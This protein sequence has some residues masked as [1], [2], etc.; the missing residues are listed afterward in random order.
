MIEVHNLTKRYGPNRSVEDL[1][2]SV[3][4]GE[5]MGFLGP[6]GAGKSTTIRMIAGISRPT[7]GAA[8]IGGHDVVAGHPR[9][10]RMLGYLPEQSP[11]YGDMTLEGFL[12]FMAGIKG[13]RWREV[14]REVERTTSLLNLQR[15]RRRL[16][17][18]LSK[19]TRQRAAIA[20][21]LI[22]HPRVLLL[23]EP[24]SGLDPSQINDVREL[25]RS[26]AGTA[27]VIL[28]T[29]ILSEIEQTATRIV[30]L[31]EGRIAAQGTAEE[32]KRRHGARLLVEVE[33][34][35]GTFQSLLDRIVPGDVSAVPAGEGK[36]RARFALD[37]EDD[38]RHRLATAL[39]ADGLHLLELHR[40][41]PS[42]EDI[43][44]SAIGRRGGAK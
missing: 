21:A 32:L 35:R 29:H 22:G 10:R 12:R 25:V 8:T 36:W 33:G 41:E 15:E 4:E 9:I 1:T 13:V 28:S 42:L 3:G 18:N 24:T 6:N 40:E 37:Q 34:D 20:N 30:I 23:D 26:L 7:S 39:I 44:L 31:S 14:K 5:I 11:L 16:L 2:F 27:T 38:L 17:R 43:F 19:G